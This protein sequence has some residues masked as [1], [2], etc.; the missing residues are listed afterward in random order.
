TTSNTLP[1]KQPKV[2][3]SITSFNFEQNKIY[4]AFKN[5]IAVNPENQINLKAGDMLQGR[6]IEGDF[7]FGTNLTS[8]VIGFFPLECIA[9]P[10]EAT[11]DPALIKISDY[12]HIEPIVNKPT[13][14]YLSI[15][16]YKPS[17]DV[18]VAM[19]VGDE[20]EIIHWFDESCALGLNVKSLIEGNFPSHL[21]KYIGP[22]RLDNKLHF[23]RPQS[24]D[25]DEILAHIAAYQ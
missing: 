1:C 25:R 3:T 10:L 22:S 7:V 8:D 23:K 14:L 24:Y 20:L 5:F 18:E 4:V 2:Y 15:A 12:D 16:S 6:S 17:N 9:D 13:G 19:E 11:D 21:I